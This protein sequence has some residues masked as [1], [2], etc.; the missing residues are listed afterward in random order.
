MVI[1]NC[2]CGGGVDW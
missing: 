1:F 2:R